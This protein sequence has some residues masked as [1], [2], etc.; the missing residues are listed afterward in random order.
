MQEVALC[1]ELVACLVQ[2]SRGGW[3]LDCDEGFRS[4]FDLSGKACQGA[5]V[6]EEACCHLPDGHFFVEGQGNVVLVVVGS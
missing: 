2:W 5:F 4:Y 3:E 1:Q 6:R